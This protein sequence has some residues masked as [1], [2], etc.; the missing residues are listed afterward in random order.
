MKTMDTLF[1]GAVALLLA[2]GC[3]DN[4][5]YCESAPS[6]NCIAL[7]A[8]ARK[9]PPLTKCTDDSGCATDPSGYRVC[10]VPAMACVACTKTSASACSG[11]MPVCGPM[12]SCVG[13]SA[14]KDCTSDVCLPDGSCAADTDV[15][16]VD[17]AAPAAN[18]GCTAGAKCKTLKP[19]IV[20]EKKYIR[21]SG[22]IDDNDVTTFAARAVTVVGEIG[23]VINRS[24]DGPILEVKGDA[25]VTLVAVKITGA[26]GT[27]AD[28]IVV[29]PN[30]GNPKLDVQ[31]CQIEMNQKI[32]INNGG[33]TVTVTS[34]TLTGNDGGG[35]NSSGGTVT[36]TSS[37]LTGNDGG[38]INSS[39]GTVTVTSSTL[40][41]NDGGGM[42]IKNTKFVLVNN[43]VVG[44]GNSD[45]ANGSS[46]GGISI[47][48]GAV[49]NKFDDN[50]IAGNHR[51]NKLA[52]AGVSCAVAGLATFR[53]II[54]GNDSR[55]AAGTTYEEQANTTGG[56]LY[57]S[58][59]TVAA[60]ATPTMFVDPS[61]NKFKLAA[62][63][64]A[65]VKNV[66][67]LT[68]CTGFDF[69]GDPRP[70]EGLCDLGADEYKP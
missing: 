68:S 51:K 29:T 16:Y 50:T 9:D 17:G 52:P 58:S 30:G 12:N 37:T 48:S 4:P 13:C 25:I 10:D 56:C 14:N 18:I 63:A 67:G 43:F 54:T 61:Q 11:T 49:G 57:N 15:A 66:V 42:E 35:I 26:T 46:V 38:G 36:V 5:Y 55:G 34:S 32:G 33:G 70:Q 44:N 22:T 60:P 24:N 31:R 2:A 27:G 21:V 69:E 20:T 3:H 41:G 53:N 62:T 65:T 7:E 39:G 19:A 28:A 59:Y 40:T 64:P 23:S 1:V 6:K 45:P 47:D 8:D